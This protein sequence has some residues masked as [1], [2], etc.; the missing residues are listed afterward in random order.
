MKPFRVRM[1]NELIKAYGM[2][3]M[4]KPMDVDRDFVQNVDFTLFHSDDYIDVL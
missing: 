4:M 2:D 1:T 3:S